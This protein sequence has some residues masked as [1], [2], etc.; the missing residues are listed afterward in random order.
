M[1]IL[2][3]RETEVLKLICEDLLNKQIAGRLNISQRSVESHRHSICHKL[4]ARTPVGLV[5]WALRNK[6]IEL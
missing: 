5:L 4:N 1:S 6:M 3:P 2:T